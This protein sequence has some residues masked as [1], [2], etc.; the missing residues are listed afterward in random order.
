[1]S[2]EFELVPRP[3]AGAFDQVDLAAMRRWWDPFPT[4]D[5]P[6]GSLLVFPDQEV[7]AT[8]LERLR[9]DPA[10]NDYLTPYVHFDRD[11]VL[12]SVVGDEVTDRRFHDFAVWCQQRWPCELQYLGEPV[13]ADDI[14]AASAS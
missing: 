9:R 7:R 6:D 11:R 4:A 3:P 12:L 8:R 5:A 10:K 1:V 14:L 13:P 2:F